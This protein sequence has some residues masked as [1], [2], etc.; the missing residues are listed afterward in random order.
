TWTFIGA[1]SP[2]ARPPADG[3]LYAGARESAREPGVC[4]GARS[5]LRPTRGRLPGSPSGAGRDRRCSAP[6]PRRLL[7]GATEPLAEAVSGGGP[8]HRGRVPPAPGRWASGD[9]RLGGDTRLSPTARPRRERAA[10]APRRAARAPAAVRP[11]S[12]G[13]LAA[14]VRLSAAGRQTARHR[15]PS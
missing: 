7:E 10:A 13:L 14:G 11:G 6:A 12:G 5:L 15:G 3:R 9:H 2:R 8:R 1:R 4:T